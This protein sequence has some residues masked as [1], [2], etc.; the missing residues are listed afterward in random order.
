LTYVKKSKFVT[1][2]AWIFIGVSIFSIVVYSLQIIVLNSFIPLAEMEK[3]INTDQSFANGGAYY[4]FVFSNLN[5]VL[6][7]FLGSTIILLISSIGLL[8][9][10]NWA[11]L[12][13][14][15][16][17]SLSILGAL[18]GMGFQIYFTLDLFPK[19][20]EGFKMFKIAFILFSLFFTIGFSAFLGWI[21]KKLTSQEIKNEFS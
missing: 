8:K 13:F 10:K 19:D 20:E 12:V 5:Y 18:A 7:S 16:I 17:I 6:G 21:I 2:V 14:I 4:K 1:V 11:R 9:R 15:V 3:E